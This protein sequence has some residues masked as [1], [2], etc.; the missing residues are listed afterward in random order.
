M[1]EKRRLYPCISYIPLGIVFIL[2]WQLIPTQMK[3]T[4]N[5]NDSTF[6]LCELLIKMQYI[7][8]PFSWLW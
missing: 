6:I 7:W 5:A 1:A 3:C 8:G 4:Y 2:R